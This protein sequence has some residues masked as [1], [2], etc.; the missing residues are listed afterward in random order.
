MGIYAAIAALIVW[1]VGFVAGARQASRRAAKRAMTPV[2]DYDV[3]NPIN[4]K[5]YEHKYIGRSEY[6]TDWYEVKP[7]GQ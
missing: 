6:G 2:P 3:N 4:R 7:F 5:H 1:A